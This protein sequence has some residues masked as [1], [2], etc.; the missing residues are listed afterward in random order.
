MAFFR[1]ADG[2]SYS[3]GK[4]VGE[5][6]GDGAM[7]FYCGDEPIAGIALDKENIDF[8]IESL[9]EFRDSLPDSIKDF[10]DARKIVKSHRKEE[11]EK[12]KLYRKVKEGKTNDSN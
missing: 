11:L 7:F 8:M 1:Y 3:V 2:V 4:V 12:A 6:T 10:S 5:T 9:K